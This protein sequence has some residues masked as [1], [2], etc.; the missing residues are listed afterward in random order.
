MSSDRLS[1]FTSTDLVS[2]LKVF[3][4]RDVRLGLATTAT[5]GPAS[6]DCCF[7][8]LDVGLGLATALQAVARR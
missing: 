1:G 3:H 4:A 6:A 2:E 5:G 8:A 7:Y